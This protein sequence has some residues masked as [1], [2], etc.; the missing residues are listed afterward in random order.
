MWKSK[1]TTILFRGKNVRCCPKLKY[2]KKIFFRFQLEFYLTGKENR[3]III[4]SSNE[5]AGGLKKYQFEN[6][7]KE[8]MIKLIE[9]K[10]DNI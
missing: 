2:P 6:L 3:Q 4:T 7:K 10:L 5:I 1:N 8:A 9:N